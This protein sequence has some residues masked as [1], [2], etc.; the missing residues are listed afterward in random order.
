MSLLTADTHRRCGLLLFFSRSVPVPHGGST[1]VGSPKVVRGAAVLGS[2]RWYRAGSSAVGQAV[3]T[4]R[5]LLQPK[6]SHLTPFRYET[7]E[8]R[9]EQG[10]G[11]RGWDER[12][13]SDKDRRR[14]AVATSA[15][16]RESSEQARARAHTYRESTAGREERR[17]TT[18]RTG[19]GIRNAGS[20]RLLSPPLSLALRH[21][22]QLQHPGESR[23]R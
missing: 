22:Q 7:L 11:A 3:V 5:A 9:H 19:V 2:L 10:D 14:E 17:A 13:R 6:K 16:R 20:P 21:C 18:A 23:F 1:S 15:A 8:N 12:R 4:N